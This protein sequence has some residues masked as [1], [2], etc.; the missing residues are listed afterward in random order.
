MDINP[1]VKSLAFEQNFRFIFSME[2]ASARA[3]I[4]QLQPLLSQSFTAAASLNTLV[5]NALQMFRRSSSSRRENRSKEKESWG[6]WRKGMWKKGER[7]REGQRMIS[8]LLSTE[9]CCLKSGDPHDAF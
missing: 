9:A 7:S 5:N 8:R 6:K 3:L 4:P 2:N 1:V